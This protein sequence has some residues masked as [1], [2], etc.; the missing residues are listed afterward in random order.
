MYAVLYRECT[1]TRT[2]NCCRSLACC[3]YV[4]YSII[5]LFVMTKSST[6]L[7]WG[8]EQQQREKKEETKLSH[9]YDQKSRRRRKS[10]YSQE[11]PKPRQV[12]KK[13]KLKN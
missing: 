2:S 13:Q 8:M 9:S 5:F 7:E 6:C 1:R 3:S 12:K 4:N 11:P 10:Y